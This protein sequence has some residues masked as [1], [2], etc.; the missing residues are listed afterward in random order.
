MR[1][2]SYKDPK[3]RCKGTFVDGFDKPTVLHHVEF[4]VKT[5]IIHGET[6]TL[7]STEKKMKKEEVVEEEENDRGAGE[8]LKPQPQIRKH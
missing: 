4:K 3:Q 6:T 5:Q 2:S 1:I 8:S 7:A